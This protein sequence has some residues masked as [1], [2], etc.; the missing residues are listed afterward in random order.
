MFP[1]LL[2]KR[3]R[4]L[5]EQT[6]FRTLSHRKGVD[7]AS[8]D[9]LGFA[10]DPELV[11]RFASATGDFYLGSSGSRLLRGNLEIHEKAEAELAKF[12]GR[13]TALLFS[14][15]YQA[16]VG[17]LSA[18]LGPDDVVFS[19]ELNH[20][21]IIDG[22]RLSRAA[23]VV[24]P[25]RNV[26]HLTK[27]LEEQA[28]CKGLK[29]IVT[30]SLFSMEGDIAP[31]TE[32]AE[33]AKNYD[34]L[35][36]VDEAHATAIFGSMDGKRGGGLCEALGV[37][38]DVFASIHTGGKAL[39]V[40][41]GWVAGDQR[42]KDYIVNFG[43]SFIFS[44]APMPALPLALLL[45]LQYW[46]EVGPKRATHLRTTCLQFKEMLKELAKRTGIETCGAEGPIFPVILGS[47]ERALSVANHLQKAGFDVRAIRPPTVPAGRA[48]IRITLPWAVG[49][50]KLQALRNSLASALELSS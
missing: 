7:F 37:T 31:L 19:D 39:G 11:R 35:L 40:A 15:G 5:E 10:Q 9:Y 38:K 49:D 6:Q 13:E 22:I 26:Y 3:L 43:R 20:A 33:T 34:S 2:D 27:S 17:L 23:K 28:D 47:N 46:N 25:H 18:L 50:D 1:S 14:S 44:T 42:L 12:V 48:R 41:G 8:N 30:E 29:V 45:S 32:L 36:I 16:N 24:Y 4:T 21:S